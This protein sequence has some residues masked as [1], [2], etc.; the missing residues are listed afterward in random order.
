MAHPFH[1]IPPPT[2]TQ[3]DASSLLELDDDELK[4]VA[5]E[6]QDLKT[7]LGEGEPHSS[8]PPSPPPVPPS[9]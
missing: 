6:V 8:S 9:S 2:D 1:F 4:V 7:R 5:S 3:L